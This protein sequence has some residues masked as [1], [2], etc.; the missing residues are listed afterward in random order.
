VPTWTGDWLDAL[1][2]GTA[3]PACIDSTTPL[4]TCD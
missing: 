1:A 2:A 3:P 4:P